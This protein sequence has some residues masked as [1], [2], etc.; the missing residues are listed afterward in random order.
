PNGRC[1]L[2]WRASQSTRMEVFDSSNA[3][4]AARLRA[5]KLPPQPTLTGATRVTKLPLPARA[6]SEVRSSRKALAWVR[7]ESLRWIRRRCSS[8]GTLR[9]AGSAALAMAR[10]AC[11]RL[12]RLAVPASMLAACRAWVAV[13][14]MVASVSGLQV[15]DDPGHA[16]D[17]QDRAADCQ[18]GRVADAL[19]ATVAGRV[20]GRN[21]HEHGGDAG[22]LKP[23]AG[24]DPGIHVQQAHQQAGGQHQAQQQSAG[25]HVH[26]T[27]AGT[28]QR[29]HRRLLD[30]EA[31]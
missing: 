29:L 3:N 4:A 7:P 15:P 31:E 10:A 20:V 28:A 13:L 22:P 9:G 2:G 11:V 19:P 30:A 27:H 1:W 25:R 21:G 6:S 26:G 8:S 18:G 12:T 24:A 14:D 5:T 17:R 23:G 16:V